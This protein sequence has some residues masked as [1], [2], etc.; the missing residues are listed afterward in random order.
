MTLSQRINILEKTF[1]KLQTTSSIVLKRYIISQLLQELD[2]DFM[3]AL[4][5]LAGKHKIGY[6]YN[7]DIVFA[8]MN[9]AIPAQ[10][11]GLTLRQYLAPLY[12]PLLEHNLTNE[13]IAS[14][15][16]EVQYKS[17]FVANLVNRKYRLGIGNSLLV[18]SAEA[19]MLA[20]KFDGDIYDDDN[21]IF[22]TEKLDGNRCIAKFDGIEWKYYSRNGKLMNVSFDMSDFDKDLVYDGEVMSVEQTRASMERTIHLLDNTVAKAIAENG[23][24][25]TMEFSKTSGVINSKSK[26]KQLM[27]NI[28]D[29]QNTGLK[30]TERREILNHCKANSVWNSCNVRIVPILR[31]Y[32]TAGE[33]KLHSGKI[34]DDMVA[35]GAEGI[36]F[37]RGSGL[38]ESKR[39]SELLK[40]KPSNT[41]DMVVVDWNYGDG[42]YEYMVGNIIAECTLPDYRKVSCK[43]G[44]GLSD[45]QREEWALCPSNIL[46]KIIE[47]EYFSLSQNKDTNGSMTYSL[48]FPRLKRVRD[49]KLEVS[50]Y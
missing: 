42:K 10:Y 16:K 18:K 27:Y 32:N 11:E 21:G 2:D 22:V 50:P 39:T 38:Y 46:G 24:K 48:R 41:M 31:R 47:V 28:F 13:R 12:K 43:I 6:T 5:I 4:E 15:V 35:M 1:D 44:S 19:P 30:Y 49:D 17:V 29:I 36:M 40:Y 26:D 33:L 37:N 3:Y 14:A 34:L 23:L 45:E 7:G 9:V 20:K 8:N 25:S